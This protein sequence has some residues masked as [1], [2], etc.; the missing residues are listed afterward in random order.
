MSRQ[1]LKQAE[2]TVFHALWQTAEHQCRQRPE[3]R[4]S[5]SGCTAQ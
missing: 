5:E 4:G 3:R 2:Q 1:P